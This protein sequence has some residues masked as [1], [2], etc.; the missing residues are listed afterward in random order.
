[1]RYS[2]Y[3]FIGFALMV[4]PSQLC[5]QS[6]YFN[7]RYNLEPFNTWDYA[8]TILQVGDGY[9]ISASTGGDNDLYELALIKIDTEGQVLWTKFMADSNNDYAPGYSGSLLKYH[10]GVYFGAGI[11]R[12]YTS[13]WVHDRGMLIKYNNEFDTLWKKEYGEVSIPFDTA[14]LFRNLT[15]S[16]DNGIVMTGSFLNESGNT[17]AKAY[18]IKTDTSGN[19]LWEHVY[20]NLTGDVQ[21]YSVI[22]TSDGGY[23]IGAFQYY[24]IPSPNETGDPIVIKTDSLGNFEWVKNLGGPYMDSHAMLARTSEGNILAYCTYAVVNNPGAD[25]FKSPQ[26]TKMDND[27][28]TIWEKRYLQP[29]YNTY[30]G[31]LHISGNGSI[32][33]TGKTMISYPTNAGWMMKISSSG[34]SLWY[35]Q[36]R[37][38]TGKDSEHMLSDVIPTADSGYIA[39]GYVNPI[40]PDTGTQDVWVV[41]MD[42]M[43]CESENY[44][45]VSTKE[46]EVAPAGQ[47]LLYPNPATEAFSVKFQKLHTGSLCI[48]DIYGRQTAEIHIPEG[49]E[50]AVV[51]CAAWPPGIYILHLQSRGAVVSKGKIL[52]Q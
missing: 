17:D 51:N 14:Y 33:F 37:L 31:N 40:L 43:G 44:C 24:H 30:P 47:L 36:Y 41:K 25:S 28:H 35:R 49:E 6:V 1:M 15:F 11:A 34:D 39:C 21:G 42:S 3:V 45:W 29:Q 32:L 16:A 7:R 23:A 8:K 38:M 50:T 46:T 52:K 9:I 19:K 26:L 20:T 2:L 10:D 13:N 12:S 27:G 48:F 4:C 5:A 18:L 22:S